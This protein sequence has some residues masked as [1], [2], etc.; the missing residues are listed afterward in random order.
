[1][2][3]S[4]PSLC[5]FSKYEAA[6]ETLSL[7]RIIFFFYLITPTTY[8]VLISES[9]KMLVVLSSLASCF[10]SLYTKQS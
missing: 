10:R 7:V 9:L 8:N 6:A 1:M 4:I 5:L 2:R 3:R